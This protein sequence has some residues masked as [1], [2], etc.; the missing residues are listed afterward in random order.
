[1]GIDSE[2]NDFPD[3]RKEVIVVQERIV[4][5][6]RLL[7]QATG[8]KVVHDSFFVHIC[9]LDVPLKDEPFQGKIYG[10]HIDSGMLGNEALGEI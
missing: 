3:V 10:R 1:M 9:S 7:R 4:G 5:E 8:S 6:F 2:G